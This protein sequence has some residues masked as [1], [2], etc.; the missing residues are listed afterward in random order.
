M[1]RIKSFVVVGAMSLLVLG[2]TANPSV[3]AA[4]DENEPRDVIHEVSRG[5][6]VVDPSEELP[7]SELSELPPE[8]DNRIPEDLWDLHD[9]L[10]WTLDETVL[11]GAEWDSETG[12]LRVYV[13]PYSSLDEQSEIQALSDRL[14]VVVSDHSREELRSIANRL[15]ETRVDGHLIWGV[16]PTEDFSGINVYVDGPSES[17][18]RPYSTTLGGFSAT[19]HAQSQPVP[20]VGWRWG[21]YAAPHLGGAYMSYPVPGGRIACSTG[22]PIGNNAGDRAVTTAHHCS[23]AGQN[24]SAGQN[25]STFLGSMVHPARQNSDMARLSSRAG[26]TWAPY[27][28]IGAHNGSSIAALRGLNLWPATGSTVCYSGTYS[29]ETCG[30][31][32]IQAFDNVCYAGHSPC[33][34]NLI[35]TAHSTLAA[36][37]QGDSGGPVLMVNNG[38]LLGAGVISGISPTGNPPSWDPCRGV[39]EDR[40]CSRNV[41][42][43]PMRTFMVPNSNWGLLV[44]PD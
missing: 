1:I 40:V 42:Y 37:G 34:D 41:L 9:E 16:G 14:E 3:S 2:L 30:N 25:Q 35:F 36:A 27:V 5:V 32:V 29:G 15:T 26:G 7:D 28:Y 38:R 39:T 12:T 11:N 43:A 31:Q 19:I 4:G 21:D 23:P 6:V 44:V 22:L 8:A 18:F 13:S 33:Y 10:V 20:A 24:W 17:D